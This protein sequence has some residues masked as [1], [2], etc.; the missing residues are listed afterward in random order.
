MGSLLNKIAV[1]VKED[2]EKAE[3]MNAFFP[4]VLTAEASPQESQI[5]GQGE[6]GWRK[7]DLPLVIEALTRQA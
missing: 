1:P 7:E 6:E 2:R 5:L 4:S 3:L